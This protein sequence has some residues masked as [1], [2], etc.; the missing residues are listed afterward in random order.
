MP[1]AL[2]E[3]APAISRRQREVRNGHAAV[4]ILLTGLPASGKSSVAQALQA[5]LFSR[6]V[7]S[8]VLDGDAL[9]TGLNRDLGFSDSDRDENIRRAGQL[10]GFTGVSAPYEAPQQAALVIES[11][12]QPLQRCV[13]PLLGWLEDH[14]RV[15]TP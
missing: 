6:H 13:E 14:G 4:A 7:N 9:R 5:Q 8:L 3:S 15:P 1:P 11:G 2:P 10:A 12:V